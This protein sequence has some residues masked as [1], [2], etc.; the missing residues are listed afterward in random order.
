[1][2]CF[3][4]GKVKEIYFESRCS[5]KYPTRAGFEL[6]TP[7]FVDQAPHQPSKRAM[8]S[9]RC[10]RVGHFAICIGPA[11]E[12]EYFIQL[13]NK[14]LTNHTLKDTENFMFEHISGSFC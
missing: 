14:I 1:M 9:N 7:D 8:L 6:T 13:F 2:I 5:R 12:K 11:V 4:Q 10:S 3:S